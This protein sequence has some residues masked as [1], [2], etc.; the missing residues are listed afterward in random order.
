MKK[1]ILSKKALSKIEAYVRNYSKYYEELYQDCWVWN[2]KQIIEW[3]KIEWENR[4]ESIF[5]TIVNNLSDDF[6]SYANNQAIMIWK[7]K[8]IVV[9]FRDKDNI[10]Y[11]ENINLK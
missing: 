8:I 4:F 7:T 6:V 10:R 5:E 2:E 3:Y 9:K 1:I 11:I